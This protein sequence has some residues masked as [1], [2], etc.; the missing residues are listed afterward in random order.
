MP[1]NLTMKPFRT[2]VIN[3]KKVLKVVLGML[4]VVCAYMNYNKALDFTAD[5]IVD[6]L[7]GKENKE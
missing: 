1:G 6:L 5:A 3:M 4:A 7:P 2:M